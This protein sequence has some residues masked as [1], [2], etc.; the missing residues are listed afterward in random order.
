MKKIVL[1]ICVAFT[2]LCST[3]Q[4]GPRE[5]IKAFKVAYITEKLDLSSKDA[6]QFW[7]IYNNHEATIEKLKKQER[8]IIR[9]IKE[10]N[11]SQSELS[12]QQAEDFLN[13]YLDAEE[14][15][16]KSQKKLIVDLK[17]IMSNEKILKLLKAEAD[18]SKRIL[19]KIRERRHRN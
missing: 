17:K 9:A 2:T 19:E 7:P 6:Q 11:N 15:K 5:R 3:A 12:D 13:T 16:S 4:N 14:Q 10:I 1:L 18:F 8:K